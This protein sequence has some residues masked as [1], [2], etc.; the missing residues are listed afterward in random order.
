MT[1]ALDEQSMENKEKGRWMVTGD[2]CQRKLCE[3]ISILEKNQGG[4]LYK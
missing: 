1:T 2:E 4:F 3:V